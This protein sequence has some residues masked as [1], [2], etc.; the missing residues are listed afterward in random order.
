[1]DI[2]IKCFF[3]INL[4]Y[5]FLYRLRISRVIEKKF[6]SEILKILIKIELF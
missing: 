5:I 1:M 6:G 3:S 4:E 2:F